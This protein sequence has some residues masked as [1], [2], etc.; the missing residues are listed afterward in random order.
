MVELTTGLLAGS[1]LL[2]GISLWQLLQQR[3]D[4]LLKSKVIAA[5]S[6]S[7]VLTDATVPRH[8]IIYANPAFRLLTGYTDSDVLGQTTAILTGPD[9]DRISLEKLALAVQ[10][11]RACRVCLRHYRK[12]GTPFWNEVT[13]SP[14]KDRTGR[15]TSVIWVMSDVS[16]LRQVEDIIQGTQDSPTLLPDLAPEGMLVNSEM[17]IA[18]INTAGLK[19]LGA[20]SAEQFVGRPAFDILHPDFHQEVLRRFAQ[21]RASGKPVARIEERFVRVDGQPIDV[22]VSAAPISWQGTDSFLV[23]FSDISSRKQTE[24]TTR[25][26]QEHLGQAQVIAHLGSWEWDI[27]SGNEIWSDEQGR[28]FGYE[29]G[30]VT[31]IH[32]TFKNALHPEDRDRVL[33]AVERSL[34][35]GAPYDVECRI[36]QTG[37]DIRFVRCRG[38]VERDA[39]DQPIRMAGTVQ[40]VTENKLIEQVAQEREMQFK[41]VVE[42]APNGMLMVSQDGIISL[43]NAQIETMFGYAREELL[44]RSVEM[45][46]PERFRPAHPEHRQAFL[47]APTA[48][49]MG[50]GRELYGLRKDGTEFPVEIGLNPLQASSGPMVLASIADITMRRQSEQALRESRERLD[51]AVQAAHVG[52]FE[53]D[54]RTDSLYWSPILQSIF[55]VSAEEPAS[56]QRYVELI[57]RT[58][59]DRILTAI[60]RAHDPTSDGEYHVEHQ[61]VRPDGDVRHVSLRSLTLFD[62]E[63]AARVPSR[64]IGTVVDITDRKKAEACL[65]DAS[66]MEAIGT[67][68][69]GIAHEFN[70]SLTA[71]LGFS[72]LA[73]PLMPPDSKAHR[74][75]QQVITAGRKSR[76]LVHQLLTFSRQSDQ[77]R[78]PLSLHSLVKESLKLLR[79]TIPSWIDLREQIAKSI[80]PISANAT[81]MH[82]MILNLVENALRAM[83]KTGGILE[84]ELQDK[85]FVTDQI[86]PSGRLAAGCYACLT[87][88]DSGEG[89]EPEVAS[90]IFDPFFTTKPLGEG[91]GMGL[92]VV[93]GIVTA[94]GGTI[95]VESQLEVGTTVSVYLPAL[96]PCASSALAK[97]EPLPQGHECVLFV[98][99]E[100]SL[101]RLG[102][103]MLESLGYYPV[104]RMSAAEAWQAFQVAPERFDLLI[105][106]QTMPGMSGELLACECQRLR[107]ALPVILCTGSDQALSADEARSRGI[108]EF[109]LKPLMLRDLAHTIRRVL[110]LPAP[111]LLPSPVPSSRSQEQSTLLLEELDAVSTRR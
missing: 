92:S 28:I 40:D 46:I 70:N 33:E 75:I 23:C 20:T 108:T 66:K 52:I 38:I 16:H 83:Q 55:G 65:R 6:C 104:V 87:V 34:S 71:V 22:E 110:D 111:V 73:L 29:P 45:L 7:V 42:S 43:A 48:R 106:D 60:R 53:H 109:V 78:C 44:G 96:P 74:H 98:D 47:A 3:Q 14:V 12:N 58:D 37:G 27:R 61:I 102:G 91:R 85:E 36:I 94:H 68:A 97:D 4:G 88:R 82:Q 62:G 39:A 31:P 81:Q 95:V 19:I 86:T 13:L 32:D 9:T 2:L 41:L 54:H 30:S 1:L 67:L 17:R 25:R 101:A 10:D 77:V 51:L 24:T 8:P 90:R 26:L 103:E 93:H 63:G 5:T 107:P 11:G 105:T 84:L 18:Y 21:M 57:H 50:E 15:L 35:S 80:R 64:T 69:G 59:R 99:D 76:E 72:E 49:A 79:P 100:E 56:L 89:M